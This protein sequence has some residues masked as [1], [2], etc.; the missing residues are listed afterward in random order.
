VVRTIATHAAAVV[1]GGL[2]AGALLALLA[3]KAIA[4]IL[5]EVHG[6]EGMQAANLSAQ[7]AAVFLVLAAALFLIGLL[8]AML[9][10][11]RAATID[12]MTALR[13]E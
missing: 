5:P 12:P 11:R 8:A 7:H 9:P 4:A 6:S 1:A 2:A 10:A 3:G 13:M